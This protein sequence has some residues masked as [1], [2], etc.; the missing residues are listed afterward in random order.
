MQVPPEYISVRLFDRDVLFSGFLLWEL[1]QIVMVKPLEADC[2]GL[3]VT[4]LDVGCD[5]FG[6][7][8]GKVV[9]PRLTTVDVHKSLTKP[10]VCRS[11]V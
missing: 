7:G 1:I 11:P 2:A 6:G 10:D 8:G 3:Q 4:E 5:S 9:Q